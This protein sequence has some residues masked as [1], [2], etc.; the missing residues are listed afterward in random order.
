MLLFNGANRG[1]FDSYKWVKSPALRPLFMARTPAPETTSCFAASG[2]LLVLGLSGSRVSGVNPSH[3]LGP[4]LPVP[5]SESIRLSPPCQCAPDKLE[6]ELEPNTQNTQW[7]GLVSLRVSTTDLASGTTTH[8]R[9]R[10]RAARAADGGVNPVIG[11]ERPSTSSLTSLS[12]VTELLS[13]YTPGLRAP[14]LLP[15]PPPHKP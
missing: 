9:L 11:V 13:G 5:E 14:G 8:A 6:L 3:G 10:R 15:P 2:A 12:C 4:G 7:Q 1:G